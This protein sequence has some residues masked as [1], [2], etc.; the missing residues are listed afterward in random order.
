MCFI[1]TL[2]HELL[3]LLHSGVGVFDF[4][5]P[6][7]NFSMKQCKWLFRFLDHIINKKRKS[8]QIV[9]KKIH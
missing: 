2:M 5:L 4:S 9:E 6:P 1:K 8:N 7:T 3:F